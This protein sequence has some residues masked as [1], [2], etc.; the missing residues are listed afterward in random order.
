MFDPRFSTSEFEDDIDESGL[1]K[2]DGF[3]PNIWKRP[4]NPSYHCEEVGNWNMK[5][6]KMTSYQKL[7]EYSRRFTHNA[8]YVKQAKHEFK[9]AKNTS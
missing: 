6:K 2:A 1:V 4:D 9:K 5:Q 7:L 8:N 3:D